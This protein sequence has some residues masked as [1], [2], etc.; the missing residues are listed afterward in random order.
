LIPGP[1]IFAGDGFFQKPPLFSA[2]L[3]LFPRKRKKEN[4]TRKRTTTCFYDS[5]VWYINC[6]ANGNVKFLA[7]AGTLSVG[8]IVSGADTEEISWLAGLPLRRQV[9][10][11]F[12]KHKLKSK[13][14][15]EETYKT[16]LLPLIKAIRAEMVM[17]WNCILRMYFEQKR[18]C[19]DR[20][21]WTEMRLR[22]RL[23]LMIFQCHG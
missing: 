3:P 2:I 9:D 22:M 18:R 13:R 12:F 6:L 21:S 16:A 1:V 11:R 19:W 10:L 15:W 17:I 14:V 23:R 8:R 4:K 20:V 5:R 7:V